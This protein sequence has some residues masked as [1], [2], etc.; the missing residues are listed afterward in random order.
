MALL[1]AVRALD[2]VRERSELL[3]AELAQAGWRRVLG[4]LAKACRPPGDSWA[5]GRGS[6]APGTVD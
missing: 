4:G 1:A 5:I 6:A 2:E 3:A